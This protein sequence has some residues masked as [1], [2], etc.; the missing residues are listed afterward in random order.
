MLV[1]Y[2]LLGGLWQVSVTMF[3]L[4]TIAMLFAGA[5]TASADTSRDPDSGADTIDLG[6]TTAPR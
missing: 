3:T 1:R 2:A 4:C 6:D 5:N